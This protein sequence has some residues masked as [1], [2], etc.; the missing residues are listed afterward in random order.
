MARPTKLDD[1]TAKKIV[2]AIRNGNTRECAAKLARVSPTSLYEWLSRGKAG[3][4]GYAEF[5]ER[6]RLADAEAEAYCVGV[7]RSFMSD[8]KLGLNAATWWLSAQRHAAWG[9]K[10]AAA[11]PAMT[12]E[13]ARKVLAEAAEWVKKETG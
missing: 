8:P 1:I 2:D 11:E 12:E 10:A 6:V 5:A 4:V 13:E 3:E 7:V 9:K